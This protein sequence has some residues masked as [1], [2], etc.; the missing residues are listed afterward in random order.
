MR[1]IHS[2]ESDELIVNYDVQRCIHAKECVH[3]QPDVFDPRKRP[4]IQPGEAADP[5]ELV[6]VIERCPTGA[7]HYEWKQEGTP[8]QPPATNTVRVAANGPL[9]LSGRLQI[10]LS[11]SEVLRDTRVAL[12]RCGQSKD[13]PF[14]DNS[15]VEAGFADSGEITQGRLK[16]GDPE[17]GGTL[18]IALA[19]NGPLLLRGPAE[20]QTP[21]GTVV[22]G[23]SGAL[24]RCGESAAKPFCDGAHK[25]CGFQAD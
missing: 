10:T 14:C 2:Y 15:H 5:V 4:W 23:V 7:L 11:G 22:S 12:C 13:K 16:P 17:P 24:C 1:K 3:G 19:V 8:E 21:G 20:V 6:R 25:T 9:Y 18:E